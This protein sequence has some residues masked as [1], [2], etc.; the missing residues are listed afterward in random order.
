[1]MTPNIAR[2][3]LPLA[4]DCLQALHAFLRNENAGVLDLL[5]QF[6]G[7]ATCFSFRYHEP[8]SYK[9][10]LNNQDGVAEKAM[11]ANEAKLPQD[12]QLPIALSPPPLPPHHPQ[13]CH[14]KENGMLNGMYGVIECRKWSILRLIPRLFW[15][16]ATVSSVTKRDESERNLLWVTYRIKYNQF[17]GDYSSLIAG[18]KVRKRRHANTIRNTCR[19]HSPSNPVLALNISFSTMSAE[20]TANW[21]HTVS[22]RD[23][24]EE[25]EGEG[26]LPTRELELAPVDTKYWRIQSIGGTPKPK[27]RNCHTVVLQNECKMIVR[28]VP[29]P[30]RLLPSSS[31]NIGLLVFKIFGGMHRKTKLND[32]FSCDLGMSLTFSFHPLMSFPC[33]ILP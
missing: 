12:L 9:E 33:L 32:C 3:F 5:L 2:T 22:P 1:M 4:L 28:S 29:H 23:Q 11:R 26:D 21:A 13:Q 24:D 6:F 10:Y 31:P 8:E 17:E 14:Y 19:H 16:R 7:S 15:A 30:L 18:T 20:N 27:W 25:F